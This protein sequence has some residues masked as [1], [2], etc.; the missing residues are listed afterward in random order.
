M[1]NGRASA[2]PGMHQQS[3]FVARV[4]SYTIWVIDFYHVDSFHTGRSGNRT[5][6]TVGEHSPE[7]EHDSFEVTPAISLNP[8]RSQG[9]LD[10]LSGE[11]GSIKNKDYSLEPESGWIGYRCGSLSRQVA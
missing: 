7:S 1:D 4:A 5:G 2:Q 11:K 3:L 9:T 8:D 10:H 6:G